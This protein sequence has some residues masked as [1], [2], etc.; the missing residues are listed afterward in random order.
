MYFPTLHRHLPRRNV[1][2]LQPVR[3]EAARREIARVSAEVDH[4]RRELQ[5]QFTRIAHMHADLDEI[6]KLLK[7]PRRSPRR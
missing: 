4:L 2:P 5:I 6:K 3:D 1:L 7:G